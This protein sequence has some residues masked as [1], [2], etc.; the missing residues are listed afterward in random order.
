METLVEE[1]TEVKNENKTT[2]VLTGRKTMLFPFSVNDLPLFLKLHREDTKG[3][4]GQFCLKYMSQAEALN[5][6]HTL[7][8]LNKIH[9]W[10][11]YTKEVKP[12]VAGFAYISDIEQYKCCMI[13]VMD[14]EF[15]RGLTR[16]LRRDKYTYSEDAFRTLIK[17]IFT[18]TIIRIE[19]NI[20]ET[21]R[22]SL[23]LDKKIGFVQE[24]IRRKA[25][26]RDGIFYNNIY[27][28]L[29]KDEYKEI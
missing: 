7:L 13:G 18:T 29:L 25:I 5:Y 24:G 12:R 8:V 19:S 14:G 22:L 6:V 9:V 11:V 1:K 10:T 27:L 17:H 23:A 15:A 20:V 21:N 26:Y 3:Y 16:E 28:S 2:A 4:L